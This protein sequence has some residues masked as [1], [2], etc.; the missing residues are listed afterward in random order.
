[1]RTLR[2]TLAIL[3]AGAL[4]ATDV[5]AQVSNRIPEFTKSNQAFPGSDRTWQTAFGDLDADGDLD[6]VLASLAAPSYLLINDGEGRFTVSG[7][8]FPGGMHGIAIGDL[9]GDGYQDLFFAPLRGQALPIYLNEGSG[10]FG[11]L[12]PYVE[13]SEIVRCWVQSH[14]AG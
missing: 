4:F 8:T 3:L 13:P 10:G 12:G 9:D 1:M 6:A 2:F 7:Q 14:C 11:A 5:S